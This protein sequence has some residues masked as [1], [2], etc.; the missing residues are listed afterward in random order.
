M[1]LV[2]LRARARVNLAYACS[3]DDVGN[4]IDDAATR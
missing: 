2:R 4:R 3:Q 1:T